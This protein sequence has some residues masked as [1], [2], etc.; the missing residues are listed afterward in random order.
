MAVINPQTGASSSIYDPALP[1]RIAQGQGL[2]QQPPITSIDPGQGP[3]YNPSFGADASPQASPIAAQ[4][5]AASTG[6]GG[7]GGDVRYPLERFPL[8]HIH[9]CILRG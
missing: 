4:L 2:P 3:Q 7:I 6:G 1:S 9:L 8:R 5:A